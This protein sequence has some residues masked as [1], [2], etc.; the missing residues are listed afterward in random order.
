MSN[1]FE[2]L[3]KGMGTTE[4]PVLEKEDETEDEIE[5]DEPSLPDEADTESEKV[6]EEAE[7]EEEKEKKNEKETEEPVIKK[8]RKPRKTK[9]E[10]P[11]FKVETLPTGSKTSVAIQ[12]ETTEKEIPKESEKKKGRKWL[13]FGEEEGQLTI[14]VYQTE[15]D[16][17]IQTAVAGVRPED[18]D[19]SIERDVVTIR[20]EREKQYQEK[21]DYFI[22]E[23]FWGTFSRQIILPAEVDPSRAK[24][25]FRE[26]VLTIRMPKIKRE[27][28]VKI[29]ISA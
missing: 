3:K 20:G 11:E 2:K 13:S 10:T 1:F 18:L 25:S 6:Q 19:V 27:K 4:K 7:T 8:V 28:K 5:K 14:D 15:N 29:N 21:G 22:Q 23:C 12:T 24:A 9:K 26:G 17:V 16:L